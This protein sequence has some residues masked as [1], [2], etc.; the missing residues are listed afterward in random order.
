MTQSVQSAEAFTAFA[1]FAFRPEELESP[2]M[3]HRVQ[4]YTKFRSY[5]ERI[6]CALCL[7]VHDCAETYLCVSFSKIAFSFHCS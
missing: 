3:Y 7:F 2:E 6:V 1:S 5:L 4:C